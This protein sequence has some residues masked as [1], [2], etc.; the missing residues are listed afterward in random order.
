MSAR[1]G[2]A[3]GAAAVLAAAGAAAAD[4]D[5]LLVVGTS[6]TVQPAAG[7]VDVAVR[8][9]IPVVIVNA[10]PTPYDE[11]AAALLRDPIGV[12]LPALVAGLSERR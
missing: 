11:V 4:C 5:L 6:L 12:A 9:G 2:I 7:L 10:E 8:A 3:S 1:L